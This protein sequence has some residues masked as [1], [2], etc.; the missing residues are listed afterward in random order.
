MTTG[1]EEETQATTAAVEATNRKAPA[2]TE[3]GGSNVN[4]DGSRTNRWDEPWY[5]AMAGVIVAGFGLAALFGIMAFALSELPNGSSRGQ[6]IVALSTAAF[7]VIGAIVGAYFG[8]RA[9]NRAVNKMAKS[10]QG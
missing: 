9:A 3:S 8:V 1:Q 5:D 2:E 10:K 7:G 4:E 6:N